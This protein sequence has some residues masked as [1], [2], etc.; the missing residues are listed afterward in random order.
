MIVFSKQVFIVGHFKVTFS[1]VGHDE[2]LTHLF[3]NESIF[4]Y[5]E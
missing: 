5:L 4:A 1:R 3:L 2:N